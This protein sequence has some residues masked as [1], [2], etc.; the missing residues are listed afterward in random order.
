MNY[1]GTDPVLFSYKN[2]N[3]KIYTADN[4][5]L[6]AH[7][8]YKIGKKY[9]EVSALKLDTIVKRN[10]I[11]NIDLIKIDVD[12]AEADVFN[13]ALKTLRKYRPKL[14]FEAWDKA[15]LNKAIKILKPLRY[16]IKKISSQDYFAF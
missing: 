6:G 14:I 1:K 7:S 8:I 15:H 16:K 2:T 5:N 9:A 11:K 4:A 12:G 13:G 10:K 3:I